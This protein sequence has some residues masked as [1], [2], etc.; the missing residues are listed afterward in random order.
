M[1]SSRPWSFALSS[2]A[3]RMR[4]HLQMTQ[5]GLPTGRLR[6]CAIR[7]ASDGSGM[8]MNASADGADG[9]AYRQTVELR[10]TS[11]ERSQQDEGEYIRR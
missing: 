9:S 4:I 11:H 10:D 8:G 2:A 1:R 7:H 3:L 5:M 6:S